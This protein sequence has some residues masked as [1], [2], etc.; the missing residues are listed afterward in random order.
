M[1]EAAK[2]ARA[3]DWISRAAGESGTF[4]SMVPDVF[5]AYARVFHPAGL[6]G[7][8]VRWA[9]VAAANGRTMH[10]AAEWGQLTGSW[11]VREQ[12]GLWDSEPATGPAPESVSLRLARTLARHTSTPECCWFGVWEGWGTPTIMVLARPEVPA[13]ERERIQKARQQEADDWNAFITGAPTF[14][15]PSRRMNVLTGRVDDLA[16]FFRRSREAPTI[17]WPD[18][19]AWCVGSDVDLMTTY[20]GGSADAIE[21]LGRDLE[22]ETLAIPAGQAVEW[23]A[24]TVNPPVA[25]PY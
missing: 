16:E 18:D 3:A 25:P 13:E 11:Q 4:H 6:C 5:E 15:M 21:A 12:A 9:E 22:L 2:D 10:G 14:A 20:V 7:T 1:I 8:Q 17:W 19:R 24:D 23:D